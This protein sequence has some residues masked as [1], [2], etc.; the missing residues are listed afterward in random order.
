MSTREDVAARDAAMYPEWKAGATLRALGRKFGISGSQV[1]CRMIREDRKRAEIALAERMH[2]DR[3][4]GMTLAQIVDKYRTEPGVY[5][6]DENKVFE[7]IDLH[8]QRQN[9]RGAQLSLRTRYA[10]RNA[11]FTYD[12]MVP[13]TFGSL[14]PADLMKMTN[15]GKKGV[16][17]IRAWVQSH[18]VDAFSE[19]LK[20]NAK[21]MALR[22]KRD[23]LN[24]QI[25]ALK[26]RLE[27]RPLIAKGPG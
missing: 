2:A 5:W 10:L 4:A 17:E 24:R 27:Q 14:T 6:L 12:E 19:T 18:D 21:L 3:A 13:E 8:K 15:I 16:A 11:G 1:R 7:L 26:A 23:D 22:K 20:I 9:P 25:A